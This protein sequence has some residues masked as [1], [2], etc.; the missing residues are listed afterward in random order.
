MGIL[1]EKEKLGFGRKTE[2]FES[3]DERKFTK[4]GKMFTGRHS[5]SIL[6]R[7]SKTTEGFTKESI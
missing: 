4:N 7:Q 5:D 6:G 3:H 1:I 2:R